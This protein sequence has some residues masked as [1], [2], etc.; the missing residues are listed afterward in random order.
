[1]IED[2]SGQS[3]HEQSGSSSERE[4][5]MNSKQ[6][7]REFP[8]SPNTELCR[9]AGLKHLYVI[10][11]NGP[12]S[13]ARRPQER[14]HSFFGA[15]PKGRGLKGINGLM[16][17]HKRVE[18]I[19]GRST[20]VID[21]LIDS[22]IFSQYEWIGFSSAAPDCVD[23][24]LAE[25]Y[26]LG[27]VTPLH[28]IGLVDLASR[29]RDRRWRVMRHRGNRVALFRVIISRANP[30]EMKVTWQCCD[31]EDQSSTSPQLPS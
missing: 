13:P 14:V 17:R 15:D 23:V 21:W 6:Y 22:G 8:V 12:S 18:Q 27:K 4:T 9:A 10:R 2:Q 7:A 29:C 3:G 30:A 19:E 11:R 24:D 20:V 1:M 16:A 31:Y 26:Y 5:E 28:M 25:N